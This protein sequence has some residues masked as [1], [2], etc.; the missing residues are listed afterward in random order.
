MNKLNYV[1]YF[2]NYTQ[3]LDLYDDKY[4]LSPRSHYLFIEP[5]ESS[6]VSQDAKVIS[7]VT[8]FVYFIDLEQE[9]DISLGPSWPYPDMTTDECVLTS[10]F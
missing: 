1:D 4:N 8:G 9:K 2:L 3:I 5:T 7:G 10:D 6:M